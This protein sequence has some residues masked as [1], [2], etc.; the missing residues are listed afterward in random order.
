MTSD[1]RSRDP[2]QPGTGPDPEPDRP[3]PFGPVR[4]RHR[5]PIRSTGRGSSVAPLPSGAGPGAGRPGQG[6]A[7]CS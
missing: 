7:G 3:S 5:S 1:S 2:F 4:G 6:R